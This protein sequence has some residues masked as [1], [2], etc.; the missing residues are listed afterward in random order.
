MATAPVV[1]GEET[2]DY[3]PS[4]TRQR[5][6]A[7]PVVV[8]GEPA[9]EGRA[10]AGARQPPPGQGRTTE[11]DFAA[12]PNETVFDNFLDEIGPEGVRQIREG[13]NGQR[14]HVGGETDFIFEEDDLRQLAEAID[15]GTEE[16]AVA[17]TPEEPPAP[18]TEIVPAQPAEQQTGWR[19]LDMLRR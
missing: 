10:D 14:P 17:D 1:D 16:S 13:G 15:G 19:L 18:P 3:P 6:V 9:R 11:A 8:T 2:K 12:I 7:P 5:G 4:R